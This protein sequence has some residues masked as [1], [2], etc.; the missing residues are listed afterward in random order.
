MGGVKYMFLTHQDDVADHALWAKE[1]G[2]QR[3]IHE[4]EANAE[5]GTE[6]GAALCAS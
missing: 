4:S 3:I 6:C 2:A 1:F 5:Q